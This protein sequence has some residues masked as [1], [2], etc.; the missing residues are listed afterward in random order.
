MIGVAKNSE[1]TF[2]NMNLLISV[3]HDGALKPSS[4][5]DRDTAN[6]DVGARSFAQSVFKELT[7]LFSVKYSK[8]L[9]PFTIFNNLD[10]RKID[11]NRGETID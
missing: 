2:G 11:V 6:N 3:A 10:R 1:F 8:P 7:S 5:A 4:I 9:A